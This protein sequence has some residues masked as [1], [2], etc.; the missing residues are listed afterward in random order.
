MAGVA[1]AASRIRFPVREPLRVNAGTLPVPG[2]LLGAYP[3]RGERT[4]PAQIERRYPLRGLLALPDRL[5]L[6]RYRR[7]SARVGALEPQLDGLATP[8]LEQRVHAV[9]AG[10]SRHGF[11][12]ALLIEA[13]ALIRNTSTRVLGHRPYDTQ[14]IAARIMLDKQVA[15][16]A[17]GEGKTLAAAV[18]AAAGALA[19]VPVHVITVNDYLAARDAASLRPL[20]GAL[21]LS[22]GHVAAAHDVAAR[23]AA[24]ACDITYCTAKELVFDYLRDR[25]VRNPLRSDLQQRTVQAGCGMAAAPTLLRGLCMAVVDEADSILIDEARVP[26]ILSEA[27]PNAGQAAFN[28]A[29]LAQARRMA[30]GTDYRLN[31]AHR[32]VSLTGAG[33]AALDACAASQGAAW[34]NRLHRDEAVCMA[35][36]ALHLYRR[37]THYLVHDGEVVIIDEATGRLAPGRVWSRGLH[38]MIEIKEDC[39]RSPETVTATQITFQRFFRRYLRLGGMSGTVR[40]A[41]AELGTVYG[42]DVL[43]VPLRL[44]ARRTVLPTRLYRD[45]DAR[46]LAV[47]ERARAVSE[48]R[49]PVLIGTDSVAESEQLSARLAAAGIAHAVLNARHDAR[50]AEMVA[51]AGAPGRITVATN[52]AGRGT[53]IAL[54]PGVAERGGL[55]VICCQHNESR[56]I[57]RQLLGRC[58]RQG[59]PGSAETLLA[60]DRP[61]IARTVPGWLARRVGPDGMRRPAWLVA[62][63]VRLPQ[64]RAERAQRQERRDLLLRDTRVEKSFALV[65]VA[66]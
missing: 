29:A 47:I 65:G 44:P 27:R 21:G 6:L 42:L 15:E 13:F 17:T 3:E 26:L 61:R 57:D 38:Q 9:R 4:G 37:D 59:D 40:E 1:L 66:E 5:R 28:E 46:W 25:T 8:A 16:M 18:C 43:G 33:R 7:F 30:Q 2:I 12:E 49:R 55:H 24:Y 60:L 23:R 20:Y 36:S 48:T 52:M 53:D 39:K 19:G 45:G 56:R 58:A 50:E 32:H 22:V 62:L 11:T 10:L 63:A 14:I 34:R 41:R 51:R 31:V 35:L 54:G 64:W